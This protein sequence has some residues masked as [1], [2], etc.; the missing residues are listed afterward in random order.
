MKKYIDY[1]KH[2]NPIA[3]LFI[4]GGLVLT[5]L[6]LITNLYIIDIIFI[7]LILLLEMIFISFHY[8]HY[9]KQTKSENDIFKMNYLILLLFTIMIIALLYSPQMRG[10][11]Y[12]VG[13]SKILISYLFIYDCYFNW[14][15]KKRNLFILIDICLALLRI[16]VLNISYITNYN[17]DFSIIA[18]LIILSMWYLVSLIYVLKREK[19]TYM[20]SNKELIVTIISAV[21]IYNI[22]TILGFSLYNQQYYWGIVYE[23]STRLIIIKVITIFVLITVNIYY[24]QYIWEEIFVRKFNLQKNLLL[25]VI[26]IVSCGLGLSKLINGIIY[27]SW[28]YTSGFVISLIMIIAVLIIRKKRGQN[29]WL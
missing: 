16:V 10:Y 29:V 13:D 3:I 7:K 15:H 6:M 19:I 26:T 9:I 17:Y 23:I 8:R 20:I 24:G 4:G 28:I 5:L 22:T 27:Q 14:N 25:N 1:L 21:I 11:G 2:F 12:L 18:L